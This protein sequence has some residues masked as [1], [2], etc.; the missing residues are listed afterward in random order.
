M[1]RARLLGLFR[2]AALL[3]VFATRARVKAKNSQINTT[4]QHRFRERIC[5]RTARLVWGR[6][7]ARSS[8]KAI[9]DC[10]KREV[11]AVRIQN[12]FRDLFCSEKEWENAMEQRC[13]IEQW[14][15]RAMISHATSRPTIITRRIPRKNCG[16]PVV[17]T[18]RRYARAKVIFCKLTSQ[19]TFEKMCCPPVSRHLLTD[20]AILTLRNYRRHNRG[21]DKTNSNFLPRK[22]EHPP[23]RYAENVFTRTRCF[24]SRQS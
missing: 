9:Q 12:V 15:A 7:L 23:P 16:S 2:A 6:I 11:A 24:V 8:H 10:V 17:D 5:A 22:P 3:K 1:S 4:I 20:D 13:L 21:K 18:L 14:Q 19:S